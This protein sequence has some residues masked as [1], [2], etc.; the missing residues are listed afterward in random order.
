M[1]IVTSLDAG[2]VTFCRPDCGK[3]GAPVHL[4]TR[5]CSQK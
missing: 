1:T 3:V 2:E 4:G 5:L